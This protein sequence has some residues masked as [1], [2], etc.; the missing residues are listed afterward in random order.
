MHNVVVGIECCETKATVRVML[1]CQVGEYEKH[2]GPE[3]GIK[4]ARGE[5]I[6]DGAIAVG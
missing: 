3:A 1:P 4:Q 5:Q 2:P 6:E